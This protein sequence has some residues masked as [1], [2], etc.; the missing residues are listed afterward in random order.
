MDTRTPPPG[1]GPVEA[2]RMVPRHK[3]V[4]PG[5]N[6]PV[7][8]EK[9]ADATVNEQMTDAEA[10]WPM[11][12]KLKHP[13]VISD[14]KTKQVMQQIDVLELREP[15][16]ADII[17]CGVPVIVLDYQE[18]TTTFDAPKMASMIARLSKIAPVYISLMNPVDFINVATM[19]Q[20]N[21]LPDLG[22]L[23]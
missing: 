16:A 20:R 3:V 8:Q 22:R 5:T 6:E 18:G 21:F 15:T 12:L 2:P 23:V 9:L 11:K 13:I 14:A 10:T 4:V 19:I 1:A 7:D 17:A